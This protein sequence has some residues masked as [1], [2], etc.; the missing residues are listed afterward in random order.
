[1]GT[2]KA[3]KAMEPQLAYNEIVAVSHP[4]TVWTLNITFVCCLN[5]KYFKG[6]IEFQYLDW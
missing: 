1:M 5:T 4:Y 3:K 6:T 2:M